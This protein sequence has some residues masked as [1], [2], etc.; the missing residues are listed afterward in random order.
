MAALTTVQ[1]YA[2]VRQAIQILTTLDGDGNRRDMASF[3]V[4]GM[5]VSYGANQLEWLQ[6]RERELAKRITQRNSRKRVTP[7]FT[8]GSSLDYLNL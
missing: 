6:N 1:E 3:A 5:Q 4:D 2:A 8:G 7:D